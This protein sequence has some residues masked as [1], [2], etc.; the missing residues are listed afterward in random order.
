MFLRAEG[1]DAKGKQVRI[2]WIKSFKKIND[3][4]MLKDLEVQASP[5]HRT[6]LVVREVNGRKTGLQDESGDSDSGQ[7]TPI[8]IPQED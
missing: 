7:A 6:K 3:R 2:L 4:W 8:A 1:L 5:I